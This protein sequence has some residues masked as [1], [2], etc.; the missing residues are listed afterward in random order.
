LQFP[1]ASLEIAFWEI[2]EAFADAVKGPRGASALESR[3]FHP[4]RSQ[5]FDEMRAD[6]KIYP[7]PKHSEEWVAML[8]LELLRTVLSAY[9]Y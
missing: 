4:G 7:T 9:Y 5:V 8:S 3:A 6:M 2:L 1:I